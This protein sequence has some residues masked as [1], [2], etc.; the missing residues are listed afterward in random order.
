MNH[1]KKIQKSYNDHAMNHGYHV[2][3]HGHHYGMIMTMFRP[4]HGMAAMFFNP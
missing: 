1:E 3:K 2:K 4:A